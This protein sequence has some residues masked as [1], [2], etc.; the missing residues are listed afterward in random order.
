MLK[1]TLA[2]PARYTAALLSG[3]LLPL[4]LAPL[5]WWPVA[6]LCCAVFYTTL[7]STAPR[8]TLAACLLFGIGLYA[9]GASWI[10]VSIHQYG[11][12]PAVLAA[13]LTTLF[14]IGLGVVFALPLVFYACIKQGISHIKQGNP[15]LRALIFAAIWVIGEW[16][17]GWFLTGFPWLYLGY[18]FIDTWLAGWVPIGGVLAISGIVAFTG[19][20][21]AESLVKLYQFLHNIVAPQQKL[22]LDEDRSPGQSWSTR[23]TLLI[24]SALWLGGNL[25]Q[26]HEWTQPAA[27][28][29]LSVTLVQPNNPVLA[30]WDKN[31]LPTILSDIREQT[32]TLPHQDIIVWPESAVPALQNNVQGFLHELDE[33]AIDRQTALIMGLP[34]DT[35]HRY[36]NSVI[37]LGIATGSYHKRRLVPFGEYVPLEQW[38][39]GVIAFF[40]LPMSSFSSGA[41]QQALI[42][43]GPYRLATAICYEIAYSGPLARDARQANLLL[44]VSNDTWFGDSLGPHQHLQIARIRALE[45]GKPLMRVTNDGITAFIDARGNV[46]SQLPRFSSGLLQGSVMPRQGETAYTR[47][48]ELPVVSLCLVVLVTT[49][50]LLF[51]ERNKKT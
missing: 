13:L 38:L 8:Q 30:K 35:N 43:V 11:Q 31:T 44:T 45:T 36:F 39:R 32:L 46:Q 18:G 4:A 10:Y 24:L 5:S 15:C 3:A 51:G 48:G 40:D 14:V 33:I 1:P 49:L 27:T 9:T 17:R 29:P 21:L 7:R 41:D 6:I 23:V 42:R 12:A 2:A 25:L 28:S 20:A 22:S 37:G 34:T 50:V 26:E 47:W 16:F 19:A